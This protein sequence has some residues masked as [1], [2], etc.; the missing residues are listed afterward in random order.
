M[1]YLQI[2]LDQIVEHPEL[3]AS[4]YVIAFLKT[5]SQEALDKL[6]KGWAK[7]FSPVANFQKNI[8]EKMKKVKIQDFMHADGILKSQVNPGLKKFSTH[9]ETLQ[10]KLKQC[11]MK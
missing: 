3:I 8:P 2:F 1:N 10:L 6:K 9:L 11:Y 4:V 5:Q 7:H